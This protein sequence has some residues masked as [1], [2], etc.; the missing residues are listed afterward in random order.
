M[1]FYTNM[2]NQGKTRTKNKCSLLAI[3]SLVFLLFFQSS[4]HQ[5]ADCVSPPPSIYFQIQKGGIT[6]PT[7]KDTLRGLGIYY[8]PSQV[9]KIYMPA[10]SSHDNLYESSTLIAYS[11]DMKD[12]EFVIEIE[13]QIF[14]RIKLETYVNKT[15]CN[16]WP[17]ISKAYADGVLIDK[18]SA[19]VYLITTK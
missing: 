2:H 3:T 13:G 15:R 18:N 4:C 17:Q 8:A 7:S 11:R 14:T 1:K 19:G 9:T 10:I 16:S 12:P 5:N 6:Y